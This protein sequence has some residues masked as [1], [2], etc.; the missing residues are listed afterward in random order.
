MKLNEYMSTKKLQEGRTKKNHVTGVA[1]WWVS[2]LLFIEFVSQLL[3]QVCKVR[4]RGTPRNPRH[5][6]FIDDGK[7]F[8][9]LTFPITN[10]DSGQKPN[11]PVYLINIVND[12]RHVQIATETFPQNPINDCEWILKHFLLNTR[13][14]YRIIPVN[15]KFIAC[16]TIVAVSQPIRS[17]RYLL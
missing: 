7:R 3:G 12:N 2:R 17:L 11:R 13:S 14:L 1:S 9:N 15:V 10:F 4:V 5:M 6:P 8:S 16:Q